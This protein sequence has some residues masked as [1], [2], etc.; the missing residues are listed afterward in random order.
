MA[1]VVPER[2]EKVAEGVSARR[3]SP[4]DTQFLH[5]GAECAGA[6]PQD[7]GCGARPLD[8]P[9]RVLQNVQD[10][11]ALHVH[12]ASTRRWSGGPL[13]GPSGLPS[14]HRQAGPAAAAAYLS[15][16]LTLGLFGQHWWSYAGDEARADVRGARPRAP[17]W[18]SP[19]ASV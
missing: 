8:G 9:T 2:A 19:W 5:S 7:F 18:T 14:E 17:P 16:K 4:P 3:L 13:H 15:P 11:G 1:T 12:E 10:M 6:K